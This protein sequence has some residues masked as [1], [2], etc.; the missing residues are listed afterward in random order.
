MTKLISIGR[1]LIVKLRFDAIEEFEKKH[2]IAM[3]PEY[4]TK[5]QGGCQILEVL[6]VGRSAFDDE[7]KETQALIKVGRLV[8]TGRYP[9]VALDLKPDTSDEDVAK[10]RSISCS[11]VRAVIAVEGEEGADV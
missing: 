10:L 2:K 8:V 4:I 1:N 5:L 9:G 11:E 7:P 6:H 3:P